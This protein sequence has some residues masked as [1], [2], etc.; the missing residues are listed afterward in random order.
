MTVGL[1]GPLASG[2]PVGCVVNFGLWTVFGA[3]ME[4]MVVFFCREKG[5][6]VSRGLGARDG[7]GFEMPPVWETST[8]LS[9][10]ESLRK[11]K[12]RRCLHRTEQ[13]HIY[14]ERTLSLSAETRRVER[15][16]M[17]LVCLDF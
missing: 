10:T 17:S 1:G 16:W 2:F 8:E 7:F 13:R 5:L 6:G 9:I 14:I 3:W 11:R 12:E 15:N 4:R